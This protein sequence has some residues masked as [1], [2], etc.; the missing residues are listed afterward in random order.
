MYTFLVPHDFD[1][2]HYNSM[3][4]KI[5]FDWHIEHVQVTSSRYTIEAKK[6][7][8]KFNKLKDFMVQFNETSFTVAFKSVTRL[9][10]SRRQQRVSYTYLTVDCFWNLCQFSLSLDM[11]RPFL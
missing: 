9:N 4:S 10:Y 6:E 1:E 3:S 2:D 8:Y 5:S 7:H 11:T